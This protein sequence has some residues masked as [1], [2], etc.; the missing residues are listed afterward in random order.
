MGNGMCML[1]TLGRR[2][3]HS[4]AACSRRAPLVCPACSLPNHRSTRTWSASRCTFWPRRRA[5]WTRRHDE[6]DSCT[7]AGQLASRPCR[8]DLLLSL[9]LPTAVALLLDFSSGCRESSGTES[10]Q[11]L[12]SLRSTRD[13]AG[14]P[15]CSGAAV[16]EL[17][18]RAHT[19]LAC[20]LHLSPPCCLSLTSARPGLHY[21]VHAQCMPSAAT[22]QKQAAGAAGRGAARSAVE[23]RRRPA[24]RLVLGWGRL[25]GTAGAPGM[26]E[27]SIGTTGSSSCQQ[28]QAVPSCGAGRRRTLARQRWLRRRFF[29]SA[30]AE[31]RAPT[32]HSASSATDFSCRVVELGGKHEGRSPR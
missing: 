29:T 11:P 21:S 22:C 19:S 5:R 16:A 3:L 20:S 10:R 28:L 8:P 1:R 2:R 13:A 15:A 32:A 26:Q 9:S 14:R 18:L 31:C 30:L 12:A 25:R 23:R 4:L 27:L 17:A 6:S 7:S 24:S